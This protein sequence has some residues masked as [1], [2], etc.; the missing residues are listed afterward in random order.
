[1]RIF[2]EQVMGGEN[3]TGSADSA[4]SS[5]LFEEALLN[6]GELF[7]DGEAF[8]C[9]DL[10]ALGLQDGDKAGVDQ[11]FIHED[12]AGSALAFT[13][14]LFG[15][16]EVQVFAQDVKETLHWRRFDGFCMAI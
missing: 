2:A 7:A 16:G 13:A 12:G 15:S 4:L 11:V 3:H 14:A 5:A 10:S 8:D 9:G 6:G 1:M